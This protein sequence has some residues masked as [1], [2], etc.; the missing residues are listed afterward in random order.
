MKGK[1]FSYVE[2]VKKTLRAY[3]KRSLKII[4]TRGEN[5][6]NTL[7]EIDIIL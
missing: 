2:D 5:A 1:Q 6:G 4:L 3:Q 7:K